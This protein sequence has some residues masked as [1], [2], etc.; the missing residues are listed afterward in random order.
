MCRRINSWRPWFKSVAAS[1]N[2]PVPPGLLSP[3]LPG[4]AAIITAI[5]GDVKDEVLLDNVFKTYRPQVV[6][7]AA[8]HKH[9]PLMETNPQEAVKN[10]TL[11]TYALA[12]AATRHNAERFLY[13][14]TDKAVRPSSVMGG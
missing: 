10:N 2:F 3:V 13:I 11:G 12:A 9:V 8:A 1:G 14:S 5:V 4:H 7:H 6:F